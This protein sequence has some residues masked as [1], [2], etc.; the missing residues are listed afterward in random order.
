MRFKKNSIYQINF[1]NRLKTFR[2]L[3]NNI[4][5]CNLKIIILYKIN[6]R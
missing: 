1:E 6:Y 5:F 4:L 2:Y 3:L